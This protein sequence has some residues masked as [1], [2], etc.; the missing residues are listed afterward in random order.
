M[1]DPTTPPDENRETNVPRSC[2]PPTEKERLPHSRWGIVSCILTI[3]STVAF[4]MYCMYIHSRFTVKGDYHAIT[5]AIFGFWGLSLVIVVAFIFA[6]FGLCQSHTRKAYSIC[7]IILSLPLV[8]LTIHVIL[9]GIAVGHDLP[10]EF[11]V[12]WFLFPAPF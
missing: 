2:D 8:L 4:C 7:G 6:I 11:V 1:L 9:T 3:L 5:L 10:V 12:F